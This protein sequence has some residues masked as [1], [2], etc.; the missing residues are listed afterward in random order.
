[1]ASISDTPTWC[2]LSKLGM[3]YG[4]VYHANYAFEST[5]SFL[6]EMATPEKEKKNI[7]QQWE[8]S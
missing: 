8:V 3:V 5:K 7:D 2:I 6:I 4:W 1:M